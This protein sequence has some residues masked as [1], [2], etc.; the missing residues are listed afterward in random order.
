MK[1]ILLLFALTAF[2]FSSCNKGGAPK[3]VKAKFDEMYKGATEVTWVKQEDG[4]FQAT[5]KFEDGNWTSLFDESGNWIK[6]TKSL[7]EKTFPVA[8]TEYL[9]L[10]Y[11]GKTAVYTMLKDTLG[12]TYI[13]EFG[14]DDNRLEVYFDMNGKL[15]KDDNNPVYGKFMEKYATATNTKWTKNEDGSFD[16]SFNIDS[17]EMSSKFAAD[18]N[19]METITEM[20]EGNIPETMT[21]YFKKLKGFAQKDV[22]KVESPEGVKYCVCG[23]MA[24]KEYCYIFDDAGK[25]VEKKECNDEGCDNSKCEEKKATEAAAP[26]K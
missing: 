23:S 9:K 15:M 12:E 16:V 7:D 21:G 4:T 2:I 20:T 13:A 5:F 14:K 22:M 24:D 1:K 3:D 18:G 19:W 10:F 17:M 26:V 8:A 11:N 25:F 6:S